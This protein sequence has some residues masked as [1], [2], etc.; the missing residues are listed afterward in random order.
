MADEPSIRPGF[1]PTSFA[2]LEA[3][4][5][6]S[7]WFRAR[8]R[9][10]VWA[11]AAHFP[12]ARTYL[13]VGCGTGFVLRA[14][15][16]AFPQLHVEGSELFEEGLAVARRRLPGVPLHQLDARDLPFR[17][18]FDIVGSYDVLE[19]IDEDDAVLAQLR[20]ALRPGGGLL[21]TV[22][23]H[24]W[25]WGPADEAGHHRRRYTRAEL[26]GK[27]RRAGFEVVRVTSFVSLPLPAMAASRLRDRVSRQAYDPARE[28]RAPRWLDR[29]LER[30][31]DVERALIRSGASLPA[32]GSLLLV[33]RRPR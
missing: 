20:A 19:H 18:S 25:L 8:N 30:A 24:R 16:D 28:H 9:L 11:L 6:G 4:E 29:S 13:E 32:G 22:P 1:S 15:R 5:N 26:T 21:V 23:Q 2:V 17:A 31:M 33:A 7:F 3:I 10:V 27:V 12:E 14:V